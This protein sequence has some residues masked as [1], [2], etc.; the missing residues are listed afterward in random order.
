MRSSEAAKPDSSGVVGTQRSTGNR[1]L[2]SE[3]VGWGGGCM[4]HFRPLLQLFCCLGCSLAS[5]IRPLLHLNL[6]LK[7]T[8]SQEPYLNHL[9][10]TAPD[11]PSPIPPLPPTHIA[12][13]TFFL[14]MVFFTIICLFIILIISCQSPSRSNEQSLKAENLTCFVC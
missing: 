13:I 4:S 2:S 9:L 11:S 12:G 3:C 1:T 10:N 6:S 14:S 5:S 8:F 7:V